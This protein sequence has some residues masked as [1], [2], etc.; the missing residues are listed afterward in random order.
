M[1]M[2][3]IVVILFVML[4][5]VEGNDLVR[6][7]EYFENEMIKI[8]KKNMDTIEDAEFFCLNI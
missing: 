4:F 8:D 7:E 5:F 6:A 3:K 1:S 2:K